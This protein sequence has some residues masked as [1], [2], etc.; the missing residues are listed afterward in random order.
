MF[1]SGWISKIENSFFKKKKSILALNG[2]SCRYIQAPILLFHML[3]R[4][5]MANSCIRLLVRHWLNHLS[6]VFDGIYSQ[7]PSNK[8]VRSH[9][10]FSSRQLLRGKKIEKKAIKFRIIRFKN[11]NHC[12]F[13]TWHHKFHATTFFFN[14]IGEAFMLTIAPCVN[15]EKL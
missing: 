4:R 1:F 12:S 11:V 6:F 13:H 8:K 5:R 10:I 2:L 3:N 14:K 9:R 15:F 7:L